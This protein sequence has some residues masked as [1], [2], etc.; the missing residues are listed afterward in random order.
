MQL[1][2]F[3]PPLELCR[4]VAEYLHTYDAVEL[5]QVSK[6]WHRAVRACAWLW[7][8]CRI[9]SYCL[10]WHAM[11]M[12]RHKRKRETIFVEPVLWSKGKY[13]LSL[14][15]GLKSAPAPIVLQNSHVHAIANHCTSVRKLKV[16]VQDADL[17]MDA[18]D[19]LT[20]SCK[21]LVTVALPV[22][23]ISVMDVSGDVYAP[24]S[25]NVQVM[26]V[27]GDAQLFAS[28]QSCWKRMWVGPSLV[29]LK[30]SNITNCDQTML[31]AM[32]SCAPTLRELLIFDCL[33][34]P[35]DAANPDP[36]LLHD[37]TA[38]WLVHFSSQLR[39]LAIVNSD[40]VICSVF[41]LN[42]LFD[43]TPLAW[44]H[45]GVLMLNHN[46]LDLVGEVNQLQSLMSC[47]ACS[48]HDVWRTHHATEATRCASCRQRFMPQIHTMMLY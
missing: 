33:A 27:F 35:A 14:T 42:S 38:M 5:A 44:P 47:A 12:T 11:A 18:M 31:T 25:S 39:V 26:R 15:I 36:H 20:A 34:Y 22:P 23:A 17:T 9:A 45:L 32:L 37:V 48:L 1:V 19:L 21:Q 28:R 4:L 3:E 10:E 13:L 46:L 41:L 2:H 43:A 29:R 30:L 16:F 8:T 24:V 6:H 7:H 40:T